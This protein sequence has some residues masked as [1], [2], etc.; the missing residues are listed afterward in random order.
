MDA[1]VY[2]SPTVAALVGDYFIPVR[3]HVKQKEDFA[4]LG[5][6]YN[7]QWTPTT[8]VIDGEGVERHRLEGF[9]P[10]EDFASQLLLGRAHAAR[11]ANKFDE[12]EQ[13]YRTVI[14]QYP[15]TDAAAE[16]QYWAGVSRYKGTGDAHA[17]VET[18]QAF[19][20]RYQE[21]AWAKK[22]SVWKQQ[23]EAS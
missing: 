6:K 21:S 12:A 3:V 8:L 18:A 15:L 11:L 22:A 7:A 19:D 23:K 2:S 20:A 5:A 13:R 10:L 9:L 14:E 1:E 16:S 4:R 17:L